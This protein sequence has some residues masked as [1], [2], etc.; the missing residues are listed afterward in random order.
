[1]PVDNPDILRN[2][3]QNTNWRV[4]ASGFTRQG[5]SFVG[6]RRSALTLPG[7]SGACRRRLAAQLNNRRQTR[8]AYPFAGNVVSFLE[9]AVTSIPKIVIV[10]NVESE[11]I[12]TKFEIA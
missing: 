12:F 9:T 2:R 11:V 7:D 10:E 4:G 1:M 3:L 8:I 6:D 5:G